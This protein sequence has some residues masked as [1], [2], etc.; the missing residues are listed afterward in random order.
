MYTRVLIYTHILRVHHVRFGWVPACRVRHCH[1]PSRNQGPTRMRMSHGGTSHCSHEQ[2]RTVRWMSRGSHEPDMDESRR[3]YAGYQCLG[4]K[5]TWSI[6]FGISI[7]GPPTWT[8]PDAGSSTAQP[9][10]GTCPAPIWPQVRPC[11]PHIS[12][13]YSEVAYNR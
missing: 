8:E 4:C 9:S 10:S 6:L 1:T 3:K 2:S 11:C 5:Q 7:L 13:R 12:A